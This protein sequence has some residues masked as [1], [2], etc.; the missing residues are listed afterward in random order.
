MS[1][2]LYRQALEAAQKGDLSK[3][4]L[5]LHGGID[6]ASAFDKTHIYGFIAS[7]LAEGN[8][9][10]RGKLDALHFKFA[11]WFGEHLRSIEARID[12]RASAS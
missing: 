10:L 5:I 7:A 12:S 3:L 4:E 2:G 9:L 11:K 6:A 8:P 1:G